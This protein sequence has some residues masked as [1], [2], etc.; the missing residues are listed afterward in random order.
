MHL[1][2]PLQMHNVPWICLQ[3]HFHRW[4][5]LYV[6]HS[7][8]GI[9]FLFLLQTRL[10]NI[11][12]R[13]TAIHGKSAVLITSTVLAT[14]NCGSLSAFRFATIIW[15]FMIWYYAL[16]CWICPFTCCLINLFCRDTISVY[17]LDT[18]SGPT[19]HC[20]HHGL[21]SVRRH[22]EVWNFCRFCTALSG[23]SGRIKPLH[24]QSALHNIFKMCVNVGALSCS[25]NAIYGKFRV[26]RWCT[27]VFLKKDVCLTLHIFIQSFSIYKF[28]N[29]LHNA[30]F[31]LWNIRQ[32][33]SYH[34]WLLSSYNA[35]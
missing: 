29:V 8:T 5:L 21:K 23:N 14:V 28:Q 32:L 13:W 33:L 18:E 6:L 34:W 31:Y 25:S 19:H 35:Y 22:D 2:S 7:L 9:A 12:D 3:P 27:S 1:D 16:L 11:L 10:Y 26:V 17:F 15:V 24:Y 4:N 30:L 20:L